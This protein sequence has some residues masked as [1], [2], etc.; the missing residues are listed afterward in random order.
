MMKALRK[1]G[2]S[3]MDNSA[4]IAYLKYRI[5]QQEA[6]GSAGITMDIVNEL[7][8]KDFEVV[9]AYLLLANGF[10]DVDLTPASGDF[11]V[12]ITAR[13]NGI[14]YCFQ[15]KRYSGSVGIEPVQEV[16]LG[17]LIYNCQQAVVITNSRYT[18][19]AEM[20]GIASGVELWDGEHV[21][22]MIR[23]AD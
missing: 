21:A 10:E 7:P 13:K 14:S 5:E 3:Y 4:L 1:R 6:S 18:S 22:L 19:G 23:M 20:A 12:D 2:L 11:G 15:C 17:K 9:C 8:G 16:D